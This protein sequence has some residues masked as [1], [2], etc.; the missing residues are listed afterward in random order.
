MAL[1]SPDVTNPSS[2]LSGVLIPTFPLAL[3]RLF[4]RVVEQRGIDSAVLLR[5]AGLEPELL[6][7]DHGEVYASEYASLVRA[8]LN[9]TEDPCLGFE[10]GLNTPATIH[11]PLGQALLSSG[12]LSEALETAV[13]YWR[14]AGRFMDVSVK[15]EEDRVRLVFTEVVPLGALQRFA[16]DSLMAGWINSARQL[17]GSRDG[18][19][20]TTLRVTAPYHKAF[21]RYAGRLPEVQFGCE[22]NEIIIP[23]KG[24]DK[25]LP[26]GHP[27]V[28]RQARA[29]CDAAL[30]RISEDSG[31]VHRVA[32]VLALSSEG[33]PT[34]A[35]VAKRMGITPRTLA[36]HLDKHGLTFRQ[37]VDERRHQEA[38][39]L[40]VNGQQ[41]VEEIAVRLGYNDPANF[42][43]AFRRW[44]GVSPTQYRQQNTS[45]LR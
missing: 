13:T 9:L 6:F 32:E 27:E 36:R 12:S 10:L 37:V 40:L 25:T 14:L 11:G 33:Y 15:R 44:S 4:V 39:T 2:V 38:C 43:R 41:A 5:A 28:A 26:L 18:R 35:Q 42:T 30:A 45:K 23:I 34:M 24:L 22:A 21:D 29:A 20:T 17:M 19:V 1:L 16:F 8:A 31:I 7:R 3:T